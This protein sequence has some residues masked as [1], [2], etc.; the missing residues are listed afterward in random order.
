MCLNCLLTILL[1]NFAAGCSTRMQPY[2]SSRYETTFVSRCLAWYLLSKRVLTPH[3]Y[4]NAQDEEAA[5]WEAEKAAQ[6]AKLRRD[7]LALEKQSRA[8]LK[9]PTKKER[10]EVCSLISMSLGLPT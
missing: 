7:K 8:L 5:R 6:V 4:S 3:A 1:E 10:S 9:L 2:S